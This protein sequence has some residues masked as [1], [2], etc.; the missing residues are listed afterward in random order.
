MSAMLAVDNLQKRFGSLRALDGVSLDV[1]S[2]KL[3]GLIGPNGAG[4][5]TA[6][7]CIAGAMKPS[8]G[9]IFF[10]GREIGGMPYHRVAR[11]GVVRTYQVV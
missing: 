1:E 9:R 7:G 5:T 6:F 4:K 8:G 3:T 10:Q 2:G 11:L